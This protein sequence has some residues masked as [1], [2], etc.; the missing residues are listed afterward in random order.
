VTA[1]ETLRDRIAREIDRDGPIPFARFMERALYEPGIGYYTGPRVKI[2]QEGDFFTSLDVH[3]VFGRLIGVQ[4]AEL[5]SGLPDG[6]YAVVEMG[7]G[8]GLLA[9]D[10]L[11]EIQGRFPALFERLAYHVVEVSPDLAARQKALLRDYAD[12]IT[13]HARLEDLPPVQGAFASNELVD[14]LPHHQVVMTGEGLR[15]VFVTH[16]GGR[17]SEVL[18]APSTP[19]LAAYL[20]RIGQPIPEGYRTEINLKA[21]EWMRTVAGRLSRGHVLTVDYGY[22]ADVYYRPDRRAG[23][24][25]CHHE[26]KVSADP[27]ARVGA[28]DMTAHV[29]F[30][31]LARAGMEVGLVPLGLT[32]QTHFLVGLGIAERMEAVL[33]RDGGDPERSDEFR[34]MRLLMDPHGMGNTFKVLV[35]EKGVQSPPLSGLRFA[36]FSNTDLVGV[37]PW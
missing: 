12:R 37:G 29:D 26:H 30:T 13:W 18:A 19:E 21:L 10:I 14:A 15:E 33:V 23:T 22:P 35:Q 20:K 11:R 16:E 32:D 17:F 8:K 5:A 4:V 28:Q 24:F 34:A 36:A 7:A 9:Y 31:S 2:G 1:G 3:P 27:Y 25:L 6:P